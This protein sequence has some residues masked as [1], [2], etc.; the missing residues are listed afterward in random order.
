MFKY[1][2]IMKSLAITLNC[3]EK[4]KHSRHTK[5][6]YGFSYQFQANFIC[7]LQLSL[8]NLLIKRMLIALYTIMTLGTF[9]LFRCSQ[10]YEKF[11]CI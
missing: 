10:N 1:S 3:D 6:K 11:S 9:I 2:E 5:I 4:Q 8:T 7:T